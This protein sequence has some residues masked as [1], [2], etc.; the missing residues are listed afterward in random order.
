MERPASLSLVDSPSPRIREHFLTPLNA[1]R[2]E[3]PTGRGRAENA[4]CGDVLRL[5]LRLEEGLIDAAGYEAESC[6]AVRATASLA[7]AYL[8]G[9]TSE[10]ALAL[11]VGRLVADAGGLPPTKA[12]A[13]RVVQRALREALADRGPRC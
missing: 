6:A 9:R 13:P 1:G 7:T 3:A 2:I 8:L 4:V 11:D 10:E 12:H 5:Y